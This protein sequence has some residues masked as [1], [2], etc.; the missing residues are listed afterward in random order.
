VQNLKDSNCIS[1]INAGSI[2]AIAEPILGIKLKKKTN[3]PHT[4]GKSTPI[5]ASTP[6][7]VNLQQ[8]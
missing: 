6:A 7:T 2:T 5:K 3:N 1:A 4:I 8:D